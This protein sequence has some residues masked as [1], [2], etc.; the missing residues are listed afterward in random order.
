MRTRMLLAS[1]STTCTNIPSMHT[2]TAQA[3]VEDR[4]AP[5]PWPPSPQRPLC[6]SCLPFSYPPPIFPIS[7]LPPPSCRLH[8]RLRT[9]T[10][11]VPPLRC[12]V[13]RHVHL[14]PPSPHYFA[15]ACACRPPLRAGTPPTTPRPR[16]RPTSVSLLPWPRRPVWTPCCP[17]PLTSPD[18]HPFRC[19]P[20]APVK[21][22]RLP[23]CGWAPTPLTPL[24]PP[25]CC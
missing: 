20:R 7:L 10:C 21:C 25:F 19:T 8:L 11:P 13:R 18:R 23:L 5:H 1:P 17:P 3:A 12:R 14:R 9:R 22:A 2:A 6:F 4:P 16:P 15:A 24:L